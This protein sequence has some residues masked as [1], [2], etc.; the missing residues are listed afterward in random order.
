MKNIE[1]RSESRTAEE[2]S[3]NNA[4]EQLKATPAYKEAKAK[5][6]NEKLQAKK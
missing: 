6:E 5:E 1:S 2:A 3:L 4:K